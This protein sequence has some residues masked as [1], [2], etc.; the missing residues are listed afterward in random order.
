MAHATLLGSWPGLR[1]L[2]LACDSARCG[3]SSSRGAEP[4]HLAIL[5][6][7]SFAYHLGC[8]TWIGDACTPLLHR[9][10]HEYRV[11]HPADGGDESTV[12]ELDE[13]LAGLVFHATRSPELQ[14]DPVAPLTLLRLRTSL[15]L[16]EPLLEDAVLALLRA[17]ARPG[18]CG[19]PS[20]RELALARRARERIHERL[21]ENL[22]ARSLAAELGLSPFTLMHAFRRVTGRTLRRYRI[23]LRLAAALWRIEQGERNLAQLA[24]ELGFSHHSHLTASLR[25][26]YGA[27]P[28]TLLRRARS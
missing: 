24:V 13:D 6:R 12:I 20:R 25:R 9:A 3:P 14:L 1:V 26:Q 21:D 11:S 4:T 7:G 22:G 23:E 19:N 5:R 2:D 17:I 27:P 15:R 28:R 10:P 8:R 16:R 18:Q